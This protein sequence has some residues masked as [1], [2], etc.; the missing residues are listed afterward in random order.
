M[1]IFVSLIIFLVSF[2]AN[3]GSIAQIAGKISNNLG[4]RDDILRYIETSIPN[5]T[6]S[7][8]YA[9]MKLAANQQALYYKVKSYAEASSLIVSSSVALKCL[10]LERNDDYEIFKNIE[11]M[12]MDTSE[13]KE[14]IMNTCSSL[15]GHDGLPHKHVTRTELADR[16]RAKDY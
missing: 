16:C 4:I 7:S 8:R 3:A 13:R 5:L 9:V 1:R 11:H 2:N 10:G 6:E 14:H 15:F 12:M